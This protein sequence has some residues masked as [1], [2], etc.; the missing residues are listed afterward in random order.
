MMTGATM[1]F[2]S[3]CRDLILPLAN[4]WHDAWIS[5][6]VGATSCL[7]A[8]PTPLIAYRQHGANQIGIPQRGSNR[9]KS[10]AGMD[11]GFAYMK[12]LAS[13][14]SNSTEGFP[15]VSR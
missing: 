7:D 15:L 2:R 8:L 3:T 10:H 1:A 11:R 4:T 6:L 12:L 14:F 9:G 13:A 5:L